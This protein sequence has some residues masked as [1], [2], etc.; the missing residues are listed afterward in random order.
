MS[1]EIAAVGTAMFF[2]MGSTFFTLAGRR[3]GASVVNRS[4]L[5][6]AMLLA[7]GIHWMTRGTI[8]PHALSWEAWGWLALSG[9]IGLALGDSLL[10]RAFVAIG[11]AKTMLIFA[12]APAMAALFSWIFIGEVLTW[13]EM[14]GMA[15]TLVG[16]VWVVAAP[17][18]HTSEGARNTYALGV[19]FAVGG[20]IG[21]AIGLVTAKIGLTAGAMP[22]EAN[23]VRLMAAATSVWVLTVALGE[24]KRVVGMWTNDARATAFTALGSI[25][26][27]VAGV[28][29]SLVAI[30][31]APIGVA[32]TLMSLT[33]LFLI[34]VSRL[35]FREPIMPR[36]VVGTLLA[37]A[38]VALL[39]R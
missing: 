16:I 13:L 18:Q 20:T 17:E 11:P 36:A 1:G 34:P 5:L 10:F 29:L 15:T 7:L 33:P 12:L 39:L 14:A 2:A 19:L 31:R 21:Q 35:V 26:G 28:W 27:P 30:D 6:I 24:T 9:V 3:A 38:G 37:L 8:L 25:F 23:V 4:R 22:Q 32:S